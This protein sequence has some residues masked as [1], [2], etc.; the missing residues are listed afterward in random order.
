MAKKLTLTE[1]NKIHKKHKEKEEKYI[2][3]GQYKVIVDKHWRL[4]IIEELI[5]EW[6]EIISL[7]RE[8]EKMALNDI[9]NIMLLPNLLVLK[10]FTNIFPKN[11]KFEKMLDCYD[12]LLDIGAFKEIF[13]DVL[14]QDELKKFYNKLEE[15]TKNVNE[16]GELFTNIALREDAKNNE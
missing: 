7:L 4:S 14:P 6:Q 16:I 9:K 1:L 12:A 10:Y 5:F 2:L 11:I 3:D 8:E 15:Y 13:N